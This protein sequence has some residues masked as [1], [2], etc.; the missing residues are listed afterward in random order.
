MCLSARTRTRGFHALL[1]SFLCTRSRTLM[2]ELRCLSRTYA[3]LKLLLS[4]P[5]SSSCSWDC[6]CAST[7]FALLCYLLSLQMIT[8]TKASK[9]VHELTISKEEFE[10]KE[11]NREAI[12]TGYIRNRQVNTSL[13]S[14]RVYTT[15]ERVIELEI[16]VMILVT[17]KLSCDKNCGVL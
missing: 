2:L 12:Y 11:K 10:R 6:I 7:I 3:W 4:F 14:L 17:A 9:D 16:H 8:K 13:L 1:W 5:W 15:P